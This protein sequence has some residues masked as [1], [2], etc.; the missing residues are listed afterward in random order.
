MDLPSVSDNVA[1]GGLVAVILGTF[2]KIM[3]SFMDMLKHLKGKEIE[4]QP[5]LRRIGLEEQ[6]AFRQ[7]LT[8]TFKIMADRITAVENRHD[9]CDRNLA[10][11]RQELESIKKK[12]P[13][14]KR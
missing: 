7:M 3:I 2:A 12:I 9:E 4:T 10:E 14:R 11:V 13:K 5:E 6:T 8:D 1:A